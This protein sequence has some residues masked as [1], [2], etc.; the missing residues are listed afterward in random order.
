[1]A[2]CLRRACSW[3]FVLAC[4]LG[5]SEPSLP[6]VSATRFELPSIT[7]ES[8]SSS[9]ALA[10]GL[11]APMVRGD[12]FRRGIVLGPLEATEN[13]EDFKRA[14]LKLLDRAVAVGATD[15]Q[16]VLRWLQT[17]YTS[18]E[19]APFDS[20]H[21]DLLSW[22]IDQAKRRK[23]RVM[24]STRLAVENESERAARKLKPDNWE[25]WWWSYHR[26]VLHYAR[27]AAL[28]KLPMYAIGSELSSTEVQADR[29]RK[30]IKEVRKVYKGKLT[31]FAT[32]ESFDK[33]A[34][35]DQLDVVGISIDQEKPRNEAQLLERLDTL[36][37][38]LARAPKVRDLGYVVAELACGSGPADAGRELLCRRA[39]FQSFRDES[40]LQGVFVRSADDG[41]GRGKHGGKGEGKAA[42]AGDV[43]RYWYRNSK[44]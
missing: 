41:A 38:K 22:L 4:V 24:L 32:A 7:V 15:L 8:S 30:L 31:Y 18:I 13:D 44:G 20:V 14:H 10:L 29:W 16:L 36:R 6:H 3:L 40:Q 23:L 37:K 21:D 1:V 2:V 28:R 33:V 43:V 35:W 39:L 12:T 9:A 11:P 5:C 17:D 27:V 42:S 25:R 19:I 26:L 34:F